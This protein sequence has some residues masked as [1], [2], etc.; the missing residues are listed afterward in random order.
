LR[1]SVVDRRVQVKSVE[2]G[3]RKAEL[4]RLTEVSPELTL[5][6]AFCAQWP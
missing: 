6:R 1:F 5:H 4:A 2:S 3:V